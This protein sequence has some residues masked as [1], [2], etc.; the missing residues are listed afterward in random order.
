MKHTANLIEFVYASK[1]HVSLPCKNYKPVLQQ[2]T[3]MRTK[4]AK[5]KERDAF[6]HFTDLII[7][8]A[9]SLL[10]ESDEKLEIKQVR[11]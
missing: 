5:L 10:T 8:T 4:Q 11:T 6:P 7:R 3:I 9:R 2:A 1:Y